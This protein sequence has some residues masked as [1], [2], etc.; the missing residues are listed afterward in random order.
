MVKVYPKIMPEDEAPEPVKACQRCELYRHGSRVVWG[1][2]NPSAPVVVILDNPGAREDREGREFLCGTRDTLQGAA[3]EA[4]FTQGMLYVT[5][6]LKC[7]PKKAYDK[8]QARSVCIEYLWSQLEDRKP[9]VLLCL[10][11]V[12]C[13]SI[14]GDPKVEVKNIRGEVHRVRGYK[15]VASYHPLAVRRRPNLY[16]AFLADWRAVYDQV[17]L[18]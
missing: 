14:F 4:G 10:G 9:D 6:L 5:Y 13:Q 7:R 2:G 12:V 16:R 8:A 3:L 11:N 1:E 17:N 15:V 18:P